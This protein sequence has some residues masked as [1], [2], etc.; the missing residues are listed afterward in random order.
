MMFATM[1]YL[2]VKSAGPYADWIEVPAEIDSLTLD[3]P[4]DGSN[5][6]GR[7]KRYKNPLKVV[8]VE[9]SY[10]FDGK[11]YSSCALTSFKPG[12]DYSTW[13]YDTYRDLKGKMEQGDEIVAYLDPERPECPFLVDPRPLVELGFMVELLAYAI[14]FIV[15]AGLCW[16]TYMRSRRRMTRYPDAPWRWRAAWNKCEGARPVLKPSLYVTCLGVIIFGVNILQLLQFMY[17]VGWYDADEAFTL[18]FCI[19]L[20]L[21]ALLNVCIL[22]WCLKRYGQIAIHFHAPGVVGDV[23]E[24]RVCVDGQLKPKDSLPVRLI[25]MKQDTKVTL[26]LYSKKSWLCAVEEMPEYV[27]MADKPGWFE[28]QVQFAI[29][30]DMPETNE[31]PWQNW[32]RWYVGFGDMPKKA[33]LEMML[34]VPV[35][36]PQAGEL[37]TRETE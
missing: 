26:N 21:V 8:S 27:P 30:A 33:K 34:A 20:L 32:T 29:P 5:G 23:F 13:E 22:M 28:S 35:R 19:V 15:V 11:L 18:L 12:G 4:A 25:C 16:R 3:Y 36:N 6:R 37:I 9:Y 17:V 14:S 31:L 7:D 10:T 24:V 2:S 1:V